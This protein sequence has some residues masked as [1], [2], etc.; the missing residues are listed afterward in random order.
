ML[1]DGL[2]LDLDERL[3]GR[4]YEVALI[5]ALHLKE[6]DPCRSLV[7]ESAHR[8]YLMMHSRRRVNDNAS[9]RIP[10]CVI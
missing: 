10:L 6:L 9:L 5:E 3:G 2:V 1:G 7:Q 8:L 4:D